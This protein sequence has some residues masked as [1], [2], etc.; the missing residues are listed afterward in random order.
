MGD[1]WPASLDNC[2]CFSFSPISA[3]W[4]RGIANNAMNAVYIFFMLDSTATGRAVIRQSLARAII[5]LLM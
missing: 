4:T 3:A 5:I 2:A 1:H